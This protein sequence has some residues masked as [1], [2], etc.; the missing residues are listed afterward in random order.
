MR[1]WRTQPAGHFERSIESY[2]VRSI[3][4][5]VDRRPAAM[6]LVLSLLV[7]VSIGESDAQAGARNG[8]KIFHQ[9]RVDRGGCLKEFQR[10]TNECHPREIYGRPNPA[11]HVVNVEA[12]VKATAALRECFARDPDMFRHLYLPRMDY[13]LDEDLKPSPEEVSKER[14][15][16]YRWWTG[17]RRS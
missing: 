9:N 3:D 2:L 15:Y 6:G 12:C 13:G 4:R 10:A 17:M 8:D 14:E 7:G 11:D 16:T 1:R 5:S